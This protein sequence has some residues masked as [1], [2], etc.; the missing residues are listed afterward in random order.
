VDLENWVEPARPLTQAER[1]RAFIID[2]H[3]FEVLPKHGCLAAGQAQRVREAA[4]TMRQ[5]LCG[6]V[7]SMTH[8]RRGVGSRVP[9]S[10]VRPR[11]GALR[12]EPLDGVLLTCALL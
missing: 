1:E 7:V 11:H 9:C 12:A 2:N 3:V 10:N 4:A 6:V 5:G 8:G